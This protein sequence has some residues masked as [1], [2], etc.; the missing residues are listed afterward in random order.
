MQ[1]GQIFLD[2]FFAER[3]RPQEQQK[4]GRFSLMELQHSWQ[5]TPSMCAAFFMGLAQARHVLG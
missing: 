5:I 3:R 4:G 1:A 2:M